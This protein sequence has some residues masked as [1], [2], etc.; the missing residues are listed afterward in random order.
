VTVANDNASTVNKVKGFITAY[1]A[2]ITFS[3]NQATA[4]GQGQTGTLGH[5]A[6]LRQLR[7]ALRTGIG[8]T[9]GRAA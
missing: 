2:F 7:D 9:Y 3:Q 4:A 1:N 6:L 5:D 8:A